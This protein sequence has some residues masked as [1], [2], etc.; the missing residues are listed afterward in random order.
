MCFLFLHKT[1]F[2]DAIAILSSPKLKH[3]FKY[4]FGVVC[5]VC[6][7]CEQNINANI[8]RYM[9]MFLSQLKMLMM[10]CVRLYFFG[11]VIVVVIWVDCFWFLLNACYVYKIDAKTCV[12]H[13]NADT[14]TDHI[15]SFCYCVCEPI[16]WRQYK[17]YSE[18]RTQ[19]INTSIFWM[20][21]TNHFILSTGTFQTIPP[22]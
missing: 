1:P 12:H 16:R 18:V 22:Q 14:H 11:F 15:N 6:N 4:A 20:I 2:T 5:V 19:L 9:V 13:I 17:V 7:A 8:L 21:F 10:R 3:S